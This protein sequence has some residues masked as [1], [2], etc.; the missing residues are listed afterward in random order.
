MATFTSPSTSQFLQKKSLL[1]ITEKTINNFMDIHL[2]FLL[3]Y[4]CMEE[5]A[6]SVKLDYVDAKAEQ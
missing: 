4:I 2:N 6:I 1:N 5:S 3:G